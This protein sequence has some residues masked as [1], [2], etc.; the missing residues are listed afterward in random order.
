M[1]RKEINGKFLFQQFIPITH[2]LLKIHTHLSNSKPLFEID[3]HRLIQSNTHMLNNS[4]L[5]QPQLLNAS[6][7][8][9]QTSPSKPHRC[10]RLSGSTCFC[11]ILRRRRPTGHFSI[12]WLKSSPNT[13]CVSP[14]GRNPS[15][16]WL[17]WRPNSR[18]VRQIGSVSGPIGW[19]NSSPKQRCVSPPT[20]F[21][22]S[23][24]SSS[25]PNR[26]LL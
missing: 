2:T 5:S 13:R 20:F 16:G 18:C 15:T 17:K 12:G 8:A 3:T 19:L 26:T 6:S 10:S 24:S 1:K 21:G 11:L 25:S 4:D 22:S 14:A 7:Q 23:S 9:P